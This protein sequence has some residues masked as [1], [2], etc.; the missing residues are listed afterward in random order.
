MN[1]VA[2]IPISDYL[3]KEYPKLAKTHFRKLLATMAPRESYPYSEP[4]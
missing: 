4:E 2:C 3:S 1:S